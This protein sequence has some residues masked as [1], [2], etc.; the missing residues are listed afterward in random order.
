MNK[1]GFY[2]KSDIILD[3]EKYCKFNNI[4]L[5]SPRHIISPAYN[6]VTALYIFDCNKTK[7]KMNKIIEK[8]ARYFSFR[9]DVAALG[10][11]SA[12]FSVFPNSL[13]GLGGW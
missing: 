5:K 2:Y 3:D 6:S 7:H 11:C 4:T 12:L 1:K 8:I 10:S 13:W 9:V